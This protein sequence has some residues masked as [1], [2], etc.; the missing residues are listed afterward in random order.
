[1]SYHT[2][3][4]TLLQ[5]LLVHALNYAVTCTCSNCLSSTHCYC[6]CS[7]TFTTLWQLQS[8]ASLIKDQL[9]HTQHR[10]LSGLIIFMKRDIT[11]ILPYLERYLIQQA[12]NSKQS[13]RSLAHHIH[14]RTQGL[15][16]HSQSH[17]PHLFIKEL[18]TR[19]TTQR[20]TPPT[21]TVISANC[22]LQDMTDIEPVWCGLRKVQCQLERTVAYTLDIYNLTR[23]GCLSSDFKLQISR[24]T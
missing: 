5:V 15:E 9:E 4:T 21:A 13:L 17:I 10:N 3:D 22:T 16:H 24:F 23:A 20:V 18:Y 6:K 1:M 2:E 14:Q 8:V 7:I 19:Q 11:Q 12:C